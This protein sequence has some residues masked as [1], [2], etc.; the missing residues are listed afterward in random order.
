MLCNKLRLEF[1]FSKYIQKEQ[2]V[3]VCLQVFLRMHST[4]T[5]F[6]KRK[7][8]FNAFSRRRIKPISSQFVID[9]FLPPIRPQVAFFFNVNFFL[10]LGATIVLLILWGDVRRCWLLSHESNWLEKKNRLYH[11]MFYWTHII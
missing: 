10:C 6:L 2:I 1:G 4:K 7:K 3:N 5:V 9:V 11:K 8:A